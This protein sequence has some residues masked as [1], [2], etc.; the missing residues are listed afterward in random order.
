MNTLLVSLAADGSLASDIV[1][2]LQNCLK[3]TICTFF[4]SLHQFLMPNVLSAAH[5][6]KRMFMPGKQRRD[7]FVFECCIENDDYTALHVAA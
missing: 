1:G 7:G 5:D 3:Y 4:A 2:G 6:T